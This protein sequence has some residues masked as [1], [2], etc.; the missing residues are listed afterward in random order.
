MPDIPTPDVMGALKNVVETNPRLLRSLLAGLG[1]AAVG[2]GLTAMSSKDDEDPEERR[3]RIIRNALLTGG[4]GAAAYGM[5]DYGLGQFRTAD[6]GGND[7]V[8]SGLQK[9]LMGVG[10]TAG[11]VA[12][13]QANRSAMSRD[14]GF[15]LDQ[16]RNKLEGKTVKV[17]GKKTTVKPKGVKG[18]MAA[19]L[20]G[21]NPEKIDSLRKDRNLWSKLFGQ[22]HTEAILR[23]T[24]REG[25]GPS[26][27]S[28]IGNIFEEVADSAGLSKEDLRRGGYI[29]PWNSQGAD[30]GKDGARALGEW[31]RRGADRTIGGNTG[32][33]LRT[34]RNVGLGVGIPALALQLMQ[35]NPDMSEN[36]I[37]RLRETD[38]GV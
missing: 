28:G 8:L 24:V 31:F 15:M 27:K 26:S 22:N 2:G 25:S 11:L 34:A 29:R 5:G 1:T 3:N 19:R 30:R 16:M 38:F 32:A 37:A 23:D 21:L 14:R 33:R 7:P 17:D 12:S 13:R 18:R 35:S 6:P 36:T 9:A 10:G 4:A 20:E